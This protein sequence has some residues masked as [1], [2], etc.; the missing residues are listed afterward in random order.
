MAFIHT[1]AY[2]MYGWSYILHL[3]SISIHLSY[4]SFEFLVVCVCLASC[5][6]R[7]YARVVCLCAVFCQRILKSRKFV[8]P[9]PWRDR[10]AKNACMCVPCMCVCSVCV[11]VCN[12]CVLC[13]VCVCNVCNVC[14][15]A[16]SFRFR[17]HFAFAAGLVSP[18]IDRRASASL[19]APRR[20]WSARPQRAPHSLSL[21]SW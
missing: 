15:F 19:T 2:K 9:W 20:P 14:V 8:V 3:L 7:W 4:F 17:M 12:V 16:W 1:N 11:H 6:V 10:L 18:W 13:N 21:T 5:S